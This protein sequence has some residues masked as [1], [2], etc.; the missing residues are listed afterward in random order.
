MKIGVIWFTN[1]FNSSCEKSNVIFWPLQTHIHTKNDNNN[2]NNNLKNE[3]VW[4]KTEAVLLPPHSRANIWTSI[5]THMCTC[6]QRNT[7]SHTQTQSW[8][9]PYSTVANRLTVV[10]HIPELGGIKYL[11]FMT[12]EKPCHFPFT[13]VLEATTV[14]STSIF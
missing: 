5:C 6:T 13:Q 12:T 7:H 4:E 2:S 8:N 10:L 1:V 11:H 3:A 9:A 14:I